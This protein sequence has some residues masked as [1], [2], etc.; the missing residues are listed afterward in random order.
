MSAHLKTK[1]RLGEVDVEKFRLIEYQPLKRGR[2][3]S[4]LAD[5][6]TNVNRVSAHFIRRHHTQVDRGGGGTFDHLAVKTPLVPERPRA[7]RFDPKYNVCMN[8]NN[9]LNRR[10]RSRHGNVCAADEL[11]FFRRTDG[12]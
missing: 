11:G 10:R 1:L 2:L 6:G 3:G 8:T 7:P 4:G 5:G 12:R 9:R